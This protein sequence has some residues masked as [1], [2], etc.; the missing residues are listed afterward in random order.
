MHGGGAI[1]QLAF[2]Q[3]LQGLSVHQ[4][5]AWSIF[6]SVFLTSLLPYTVK[7]HQF[8][9]TFELLQT[10]FVDNTISGTTILKS[11]VVDM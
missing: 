7:K 8:S 9:L 4:V 11:L 3:T 1:S 6:S 2:S 5:A 10:F